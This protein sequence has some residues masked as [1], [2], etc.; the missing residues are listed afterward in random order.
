MSIFISLVVIG[1]LY[2]VYNF[3]FK[4][5]HLIPSPYDNLSCI[6]Q[7]LF[8]GFRMEFW[9]QNVAFSRIQYQGHDRWHYIRIWDQM[10]CPQTP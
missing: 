4:C 6:Y 10:T 5:L 2:I 7:G 9:H 1:V 3:H 8:V